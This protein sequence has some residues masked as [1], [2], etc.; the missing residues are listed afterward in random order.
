MFFLGGINGILCQL[1]H[2]LSAADQFAPAGVD[3]LNDVPAQCTFVDFK[4]FRHILL[5]FCMRFAVMPNTTN[6][7]LYTSLLYFC[8]HENKNG[9]AFP[10]PH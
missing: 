2:R 10:H 5:L 7:I 4:T 8:K 3:N 9:D 6:L 1:A